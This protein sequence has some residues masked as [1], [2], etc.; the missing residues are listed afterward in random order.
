MI[1]VGFE[2]GNENTLKLIKKGTTVADN[3]QAAKMIKEVG[4]PLFGFFMI[5][6]PWETREDT[7]NTFNFIFELDPDFIEVHIAMPY[8]GTG[9]YNECEKYKTIKSEAWGNDYFSPNTIGTATV[10]MSE[11]Q[12]LKKKYLLK[13]YLRPK[14]IFKKLYGCIVNPTVLMNYIK[15]GL[16]LV[17][18]NLLR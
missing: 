7:I 1:A 17:K 9:L 12:E 3:L 8:F 11:I 14:Y 16:R 15:Y 10:P 13:F 5:G 6:F 4:L 2:S 18:N